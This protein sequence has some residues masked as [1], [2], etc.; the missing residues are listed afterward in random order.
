M[1]ELPIK[2]DFGDPRDLDVRYA[3][4]TFG[5]K[6]VEEAYQLFKQNAFGYVE[7]FRWMASAAFVF[8]FPIVP[9]Y[10]MSPESKEDSDTISSFIGILETHWQSNAEV[11]R[12]I[13]KL[14]VS[15]CRHVVSH[16]TDYD[17][18]Y[19]IYGDVKARYER[20]RTLV[21]LGGAANPRSPSAQ[22]AAGR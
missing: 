21:E 2:S 8:Y 20:M 15:M 4:K 1:K 11:L 7:N 19:N 13:R 22:G 16:Y 17:L 18:D 9:R 12:P 5:T 6:T 10:F 3:W 14:I